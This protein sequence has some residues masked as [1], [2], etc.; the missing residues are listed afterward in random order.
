MKALFDMLTHEVVLTDRVTGVTSEFRFDFSEYKAQAPETWEAQALA[1]IEL[2][3]EKISSRH[4][5]IVKVL[6]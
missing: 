2:F 5:A 3:I 4:S 6:I 1:V